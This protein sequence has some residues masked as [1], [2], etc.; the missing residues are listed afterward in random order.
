M[1]HAIDRRKFVTGVGLG[2]A[3]IA[4]VGMTAGATNAFAH[5]DPAEMTFN[6][7]SLDSTE[8]HALLSDYDW[9][10]G[11]LTIEEIAEA[12]KH[13]S[14]EEAQ[15]ILDDEPLITEDYVQED[16]TVVPAV[17]LMLRNRINRIGQGVG[18]EVKDGCWDFLMHNFTEEEAEFY[19]K[20]PM[21]RLFNDEEAGEAA[22]MSAEEAKEICDSLSYRGLMNRVTREGVSYYHLLTFAHGMLEFTMDRYEEPMYLSEIFALEGS[23]YGYESRNQGSAMY[24]TVPVQQEIVADTEILPYCDWERVIDRNETLSVSP[25]QCRSFN[26]LLQGMEVGE[27]CDH[28]LETCIAT[29]EQA[30]Y[31]IE[32]GIGRQIDQAEAKEILQRNV[33]AGMVIE[34][35]NS[36]QCDVIC[37]CH[38]DC[39]GILMGYISLDGDVEN[40]KYVSNYQLN[41]DYDI[42]I[43]C[44][45]CAERCPLFTITMDEETGYPIVGNL[46]VRCGQ[47]CTVCPVGARTLTALDEDARIDLHYDM[48]DDYHKKALE[49]AKRGFI[50][51]FDMK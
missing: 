44:G 40:L 24:Y 30:R 3:G 11:R 12:A 7:G 17:Y 1:E 38:G 35:M 15:A 13:I 19:L 9:R 28:P 5:S 33:D 25:C 51:D 2:A 43:Q 10:D 20:M 39:C 6:G 50:V 4:A 45:S 48:V 37:S 26:P 42:C 47:C 36:K 8:A 31:Y 23:D 22:G 34:I 49:R 21:N 29:G 46:C 14:D 18:S 16:G 32:N 27:W 41:V